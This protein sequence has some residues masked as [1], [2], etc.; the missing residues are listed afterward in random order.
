MGIVETER[1][2]LRP[3][4]RGDIDDLAAVFAEP[5]VWRYPFGRGLTRDESKGFLDRQLQHWETHGFGLWAAE[6]KTDGCLIG[7][8]GLAIP[9][10]LPQILPAVEVGWRLHPDYWG[11]GLATEGG[12]ASLRHGFEVLELDRII[13]IFTPDN[14]ASGRVMDRLGMHDGLTTV[15]PV[16]KVALLIREITR[17]DWQSAHPCRGH[18]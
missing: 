12:R 17:P 7:Y 3:W 1:L 6:L 13:S 9:T 2:M 8:M 11:R 14:V 16:R 4:S 5:D 15:D 10:W 18:L